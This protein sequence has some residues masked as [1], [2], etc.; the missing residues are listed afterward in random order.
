[1]AQG[2]GGAGIR[3]GDLELHPSL[4]LLG[5]YDSN[6]F[7]R[8]D[9]D[10]VAVPG[11]G[12]NEEGVISSGLLRMTPALRI[13]TLSMQRRMDGDEQVAL[14]FVDFRAGI[15]AGWYYLFNTNAGLFDQVEVNGD[16]A[17]TFNP[18][19]P[20]SVELT[21]KVSRRRLPLFNGSAF[22]NHLE[23]GIRPELSTPGGLLR[24]SLRYNFGY[25]IFTDERNNFLKHEFGQELRWEF[26]PK[27]ALFQDVAVSIQSFTNADSVDLSALSTDLDPLD[28]QFDR[29]DSIRVT[30]RGGL[31]GALTK[32]LA[33]TLAAG[34]TNG[35]IENRTDAKDLVAQA[36]LRWRPSQTFSMTL[37]GRRSGENALQGNTLRR[38]GGDLGATLNLGSKVTVNG[39]VEV[40]L[41]QFGDDQVQNA[42]K[43][44]FAGGGAFTQTFQSSLRNAAEDAGARTDLKVNIG[45]DVEYRMLD[46][47]ALSAEGAFFLNDSDY[48]FV[49]KVSDGQFLANPAAYQGFRLLAGLRAFL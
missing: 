13:S 39:N 37:S 26:L 38:T 30:A 17:E 11:G 45:L 31:N 44:D 33:I 3:V 41:G 20:F 43:G 40:E 48:V 16:L 35:F 14:P 4:S 1:M 23:A 32:T 8:D 46:W 2:G 24:G 19:R 12:D 28:A 9:L 22:Q 27:T 36:Q 6:P 42:V 29:N 34:V 21:Q 7:F 18:E 25:D 10:F 15:S 47:L 49:T 5:G